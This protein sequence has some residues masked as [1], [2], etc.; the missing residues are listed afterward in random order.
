MSKRGSSGRPTGQRPLLHCRRNLLEGAA[1]VDSTAA[2]A[3]HGR[4]GRRA[5][6]IHSHHPRQ[7]R[8]NQP[9]ATSWH[10]RWQSSRRAVVRARARRGRRKRRAGARRVECVVG[11]GEG[12][13]AAGD[14]LVEIEE[15]R[16]AGAERWEHPGWILWHWGRS[17]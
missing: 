9:A 2:E 12:G 11:R 4:E 3:R 8:P 13:A 1:G 17:G 14:N 16:P 15:L 5:I 7:P 6:P 10:T